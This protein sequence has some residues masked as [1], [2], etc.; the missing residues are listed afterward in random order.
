MLVPDRSRQTVDDGTNISLWLTGIVGLVLTF[1]FYGVLFL[2]GVRRSHTAVLLI[3]RGWVPYVEAFVTTWAGVI[4]W[5]KYRKLRRQ[6]RLMLLDL[7]P[8]EIGAA[9][10]V[11]TAP[12]FAAHARALADRRAHS[13]VLGRLKRAFAQVEARR[14]RADLSAALSSQSAID[15][16]AVE[17]SYTMVKVFIWAIPILGFI[18][19]VIGIS[20][21]V[22]AFSGALD[23]AENLQVVKTSLS[24]VVVGLAVAFDTTLLALLMSLMIMIPATSLQ[25]AEE[26][27]LN[28]IDAYCDEHILSRLAGDRPGGDTRTAALQATDDILRRLE[29]LQERFSSAQEE[30]ATRYEQFGATLADH[31]E[32]VSRRSTEHLQSVE[33]LFELQIDQLNRAAGDLDERGRQIRADIQQGVSAATDGVRQNFTRLGEGLGSLGTVLKRLGEGQ[34]S[35]GA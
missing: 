12:G 19:T 31:A 8:T 33:V 3:D 2:P 21:A 16:N 29:A 11:D 26:D 9:I 32:K 23:R 20:D 7:V 17:S 14:S 34:D 27:L 6:Q 13:F 25:K 4:L 5:A 18:G 28:Q 24:G 22:G 30:Q 10:T 1:A 35:R 15:A